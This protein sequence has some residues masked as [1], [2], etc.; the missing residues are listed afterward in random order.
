[1]SE[2]ISLTLKYDTLKVFYPKLTVKDWH[3]LVDEIG[4]FME[5]YLC[6]YQDDVEDKNE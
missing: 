5:E 1:M 4:H 3:R 2:E 6:D